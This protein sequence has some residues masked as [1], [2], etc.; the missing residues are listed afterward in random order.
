MRRIHSF[1]GALALIGTSVSAEQAFTLRIGVHP[2]T[3]YSAQEAGETLAIWAKRL[4]A[5]CGDVSFDGAVIL[6]ISDDLPSSVDGGSQ[7]VLQAFARTQTSIQVV[8]EISACPKPASSGFIL[9]CARPKG[10]ILVVKRPDRERDAQIWAHE[11]GHAQGLNSSFSGYTDAHNTVYGS[12]MFKSANSEN[13]DMSKTECEQY[14]SAQDFPP[15]ITAIEEQIII[16][17]LPQETMETE[18]NLPTQL[19]AS[20]WPHGFDF[21]WIETLG[22]PLLTAA[23]T[24]LDE[25]DYTLW[26][27]AVLVVG[28]A[29]SE[30]AFERLTRVLS[31]EATDDP[32]TR[33]FLNEAKANAMLAMGYLAYHGNMQAPTILRDAMSPN[34]VSAVV[35]VADD[36]RPSELIFRQIARASTVA[37]A[38]AAP[39][40]DQA[41]SFL[42]DQRNFQERGAYDIGVD[43]EYFIRLEELTSSIR[44]RGLE[45]LID[46]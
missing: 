37:L 45:A 1:V 41:A 11:V 17:E 23:E 16:P 8:S 40:S 12:L 30:G 19:L 13:W 10:P 14:F 3:S 26:P 29:N 18:S 31:A 38:I 34:R 43:D 39:R 7:S 9:G 2:K 35:L 36:G 33:L 24:A 22:E 25:G 42:Q 21:Q 27:N 44:E 28:F 46:K 20:D 5:A 15:A 32:S 4:S 6:P